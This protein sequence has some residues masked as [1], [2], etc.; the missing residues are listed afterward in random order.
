LLTNGLLLCM[1]V[2]QFAT[3]KSAFSQRYGDI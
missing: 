2:N 3:S 1:A